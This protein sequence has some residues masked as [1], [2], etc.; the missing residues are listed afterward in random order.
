MKDV[1]MH[2]CL[3]FLRVVRQFIDMKNINIFCA[4]PYN[5]TCLLYKRCTHVV[6]V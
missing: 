5:V 1:V 4:M 3:M 6:H 2:T